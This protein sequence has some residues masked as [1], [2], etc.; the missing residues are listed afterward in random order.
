MS[1]VL[2]VLIPAIVITGVWYLILRVSNGHTPK[3]HRRRK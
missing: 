3:K 1:P 2:W